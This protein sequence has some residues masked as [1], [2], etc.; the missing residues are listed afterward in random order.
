MAGAE[1]VPSTDWCNAS[2]V[3]SCETPSGGDTSSCFQCCPQEDSPPQNKTDNMPEVFIRHTFFEYHD[4]YLAPVHHLVVGKLK[5]SEVGQLQ[6][7]FNL[8]N[9]SF[10][11]VLFGRITNGSSQILRNKRRGH[12]PRT[13][14]IIPF[15]FSPSPS[16]P[17]QECLV[18]FWVAICCVSLVL[19]RKFKR[20]FRFC[21]L[22]FLTFRFC[23]RDQRDSHFDAF[24]CHNESDATFV[25]ADFERGFRPQREDTHN[26]ICVKFVIRYCSCLAF[27]VAMVL[28]ALSVLLL[29]PILGV[30][31]LL[32]IIFLFT[33]CAA[34]VFLLLWCLESKRPCNEINPVTCLVDCT[35]AESNLTS[36]HY[37]DP[38]LLYNLAK[39]MPDE[40]AMVEM[41]FALKIDPD[42]RKSCRVDNNTSIVQAVY[43]MLHCWYKTQDGLVL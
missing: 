25:L 29:Q 33:A 37:H 42:V 3:N 4:L 36:C 10:G 26:R 20:Q 31:Y 32:V 40:G 11:F 30:E 12:H 1:L 16:K 2:S 22:Y 39:K 8:N 18:F 28:T 6:Y 13:D 38:L 7:L 15:S 5:C 41:A 27:V 35:C 23:R 19:F 9:S 43:E 21:F 14:G 24:V 17:S 34:G